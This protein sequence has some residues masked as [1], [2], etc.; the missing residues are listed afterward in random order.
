MLGLILSKSAGKVASAVISGNPSLGFGD[1][2]HQM[3]GMGHIMHSTMRSMEHAAR[4]MK[5]VMNKGKGAVHDGAVLH[6]ANK[7]SLDGASVAENSTRNSL[8]NQRDTANKLQNK[9]DR[10]ETLTAQENELLNASHGFLD[11]SD[12]DI[13]RMSKKA[14][15]DYYNDSMSQFNK[16]WMYNK[17]T[18]LEKPVQEDGALRVGQ[19]IVDPETKAIRT[20]SLYDVQNAGKLSG[21]KAASEVV[22]KAGEQYGRRLPSK[23]PNKRKVDLP[24]IGQ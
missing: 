21:E 16:G 15:E 22:K 17:L 10:G 13:E 6:E 9:L 23:Q 11:M 3:R 14:G 4:D 8:T 5:D 19:Q 7:A 20:A 2:A 18:G 12:K 1:V 24:E